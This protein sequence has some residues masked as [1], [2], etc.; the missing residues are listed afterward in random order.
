[1]RDAF[2]RRESERD[3]NFTRKS[4]ELAQERQVFEA[5]RA[6]TTEARQRYSD[7]LTVIRQALENQNGQR[8]EEYWDALKEADP[9]TYLIEREDFRANQDRIVALEREQ[10]QVQHVQQQEAQGLQSQALVRAD[11]Y[12]LEHIPQWKDPEVRKADSAVIRTGALSYGY[13]EAELENLQDPRA[14]RVLRDAIRY[15]N[16]VKEL[17]ARGNGKASKAVPVVRRPGASA[18]RLTPEKATSK[19]A[20]AAFQKSPSIESAVDA[21]LAQDGF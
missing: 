4:T 16:G 18:P 12:L 19:A 9:N 6:G 21:L 15:Q 17:K 2:A 3:G 10:Q 11:A 7:G 5:E 1:M 14:V 20:T 8:T 13:S